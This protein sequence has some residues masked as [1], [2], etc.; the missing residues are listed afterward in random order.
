MG[1]ET[2]H[3]IEEKEIHTFDLR[4]KDLEEGSQVTWHLQILTNTQLK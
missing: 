3:E 1:N 2:F 4:Y